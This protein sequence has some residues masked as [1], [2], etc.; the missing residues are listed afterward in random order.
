M[1]YPMQYPNE[2][3]ADLHEL[4][5]E[6]QKAFD[7]NSNRLKS[8]DGS[9]HEYSADDFISY[10]F[11]PYYFQQRLKIL[12]I[13]WEAYAAPGDDFTNYIE[14]VFHCYKDN[15]IGGGHINRCLFHRRMF[16]ISYALLHGLPAWY[17]IPDAHE[18]TPTFGTENGISFAFTNLSKILQR[19]R[20]RDAN[21]PLIHEAYSISTKP[22]NYV[23]R[24]IEILEPDLIIAMNIFDETRSGHALTPQ[25]RKRFGISG[26]SVFK[27]ET[28]N[29]HPLKLYYYD[30]EKKKE[31][32]VLN[33]YHF[34]YQQQDDVKY[35]YDPIKQAIEFLR[36]EK[37]L[38]IPH[39]LPPP[40]P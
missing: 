40:V 1:Q 16:K 17:C 19:D 30:A 12:Y 26:D 2:K 21:R 37:K 27:S 20:Q 18:L 15:H 38:S 9:E 36:N 24:E 23:R 32:P 35:W 7:R 4:Y 5:T 39:L 14:G 33:T 28:I 22:Y 25:D 3:Q 11:Y 8:I 10:G 6:W 29:G 13:G 31:I 34:S